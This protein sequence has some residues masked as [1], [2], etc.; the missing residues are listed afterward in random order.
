MF[1]WVLSGHCSQSTDIQKSKN[2]HELKF[3][4][5]HKFTIVIKKNEKRN[6]LKKECRFLSYVSMS[7]IHVP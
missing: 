3:N 4:T 7:R 6:N 1:T 5:Y 2:C